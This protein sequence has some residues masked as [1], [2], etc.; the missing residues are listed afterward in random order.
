VVKSIHAGRDKAVEGRRLY[1]IVVGMLQQ[2]GTAG[3]KR[4]VRNQQAQ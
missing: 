1:E 3:K 2:S 4:L